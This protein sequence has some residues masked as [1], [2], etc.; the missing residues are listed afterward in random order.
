MLCLSIS[1]DASW[2]TPSTV[3]TATATPPSM[4]MEGLSSQPSAGPSTNS[5]PTS[6][7]AFDDSANAAEFRANLG[8]Y[9]SQLLQL[10]STI[11][12]R[13][14]LSFCPVSERELERELATHASTALADAL[15]A[16][17]AVLTKDH[18]RL[19]T[20]LL[21]PGSLDPDSLGQ[22]FAYEAII[23]LHNGTGR[24]RR[25]ADIQALGVLSLYALT[26]D[27]LQQGREFAA[28]F[29]AAIAELWRA[30]PSS[31]IHKGSLADKEAL[32]SIYCAAV[33]LNR[34]LFLISD[35]NMTLDAYTRSVCM[36][37]FQAVG[38]TETA[39]LPS[40]LNLSNSII[41]DAFFHKDLSSIP[42]NPRV[43]VAKLFELAEWTYLA[44][45]G[46]QQATFE[47]A[48]QV[49]SQGLRWYETFF[50]YTSGCGKTNTS[51]ILFVHTFYHFCVLCLLTPH[52]L[53]SVPIARDGTRADTVCKQAAD[54][55][56]ELIT[57]YR[58][59]HGGERLLGFVPMFESA[60]RASL[61]EART[62]R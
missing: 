51:L 8:Y 2:V 43:I 50:Q 19:A 3:T 20:A 40:Q 56:C 39:A 10:L 11:L 28:D 57:H 24:P 6:L 34:V 35:Y 1:A 42:D 60:A 32:A 29:C 53:E 62:S 52:I 58:Q 16:I 22:A 33:S 26:C 5:P 25:V 41:D 38:D 61:G 18:P 7:E 47:G 36:D 15:L 21:A 27:K 45:S 23:A 37:D 17:G 14:C 48:V 9:R 54:S 13:E 49:Y 44:R 59:L 12:A 46:P 4:L 55:I 31:E 30:E